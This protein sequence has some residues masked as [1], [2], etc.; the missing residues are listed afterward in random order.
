MK[1][2]AIFFLKKQFFW[3]LDP[4]LSRSITPLPFSIFVLE[5]LIMPGKKFQAYK[6]VNICP[7]S[8]CMTFLKTHITLS[9]RSQL[10]NLRAKVH[11]YAFGPMLTFVRDSCVN[12]ICMKK[13]IRIRCIRKLGFFAN[14]SLHWHS[15]LLFAIFWTSNQGKGKSLTSMSLW[16]FDTM[17]DQRVGHSK[18]FI[19]VSMQKK[20]K[21]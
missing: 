11:N 2:M 9:L 16:F 13:Q 18:L 7:N 14:W 20:K 1:K 4:W 17:W 21:N 5:T 15:P 12:I 10:F 3:F 8:N 6:K 19:I